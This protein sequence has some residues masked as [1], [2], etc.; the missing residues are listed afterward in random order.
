[1]Y[2][3][4]LWPMPSRCGGALRAGRGASHEQ[5]LR[6]PAGRL[7][8]LDVRWHDRP[9]DRAYGSPQRVGLSAS[10]ARPRLT[11]GTPGGRIPARVCAVHAQRAPSALGGCRQLFHPGVSRLCAALWVALALGGGGGAAGPTRRPPP[12]RGRAL[13]RAVGLSPRISGTHGTRARDGAGHSAPSSTDMQQMLQRITKHSAY[14]ETIK[15]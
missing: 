5:D 9:S 14:M 8:R 12:G 10:L 13:C 7:G 6:L 11:G 15:D 3:E 2:R 1:M 4:S